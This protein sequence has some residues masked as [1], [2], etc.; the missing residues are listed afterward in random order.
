[1]AETA[2]LASAF[3]VLANLVLFFWKKDFPPRQLKT[4]SPWNR[5]FV[6]FFVV[7]AACIGGG[8]FFTQGDQL[9]AQRYFSPIDRDAYAAAERLA[10]AL[11]VTVG[12]LLTV[13]FTHRSGDHTGNA[14]R[15]QFKLLGLY[16]LGL[17]GGAIALVLL[18][19]F[20]LKLL[21]RDTPEAA[22]MINPLAITMVFVGL[23]QAFAIWA[24][25]SRWLKITLLYGGLGLA[26]WITLLSAWANH[27]WIYYVRCPSRPGLAVGDIIF[28]LADHDAFAGKSGATF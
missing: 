17:A 6:Q 25:A 8:Y 3:I 4:A 24:L 2:V 9:V 19:T 26:Y 16:A 14:L 1:M 23:L 27:R 21:G 11:P 7:S 10:V 15:E 18:K 13:L 22:A 12:P 5:E 20:C 28:F